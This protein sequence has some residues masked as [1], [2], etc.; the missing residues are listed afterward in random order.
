MQQKND[1][2]TV[3]KSWLFPALVTILATIIWRDVTEL[4]GDVKQ[5]LAQSN[6]DKTRIDALE[7]Q[8]DILNRSL[9][10]PA[11]QSPVNP[12]VYEY[13]SKEFIVDEKKKKYGW[14]I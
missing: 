6:I 14:I 5:L 3:V 8:I 12:I 13:S 11:E 2:L 4:K 7:R 1:T 9:L 10:K